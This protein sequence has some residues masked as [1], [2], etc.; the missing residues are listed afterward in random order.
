MWEKIK[1]CYPPWLEFIAPL[2]LGAA[3]IYTYSVYPELP[4]RFPT[5]FGILGLPDAWQPKSFGTVY[6][7]LIIGTLVWLPLVLLN[8]FFIIKPDDPG[9]FI[10]VTPRQKEQLGPAGLEAIRRITARG[11]IMI[12]ITMAAMISTLH[13]QS[14]Q[15]ALGLQTGHGYA[16]HIFG[17]ALLIESI[18]LT[19]KT[20]RMTLTPRR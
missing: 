4:A 2:L 20:L 11:M 9:K 3:F 16:V 15:T 12:N 1:T 10:N 8:Y 13:Y 14:I 7:A 18:W 17:A 6:L 19:V 5:H